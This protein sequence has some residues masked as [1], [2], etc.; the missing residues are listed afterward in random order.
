MQLILAHR[1]F[2]DKS[3]LWSRVKYTSVSMIYNRQYLK[4]IK[5]NRVAIGL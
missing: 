5:L 2:V 1:G 4:Y 3:V